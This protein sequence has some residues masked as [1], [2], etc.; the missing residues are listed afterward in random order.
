M[1]TKRRTV[2]EI[3]EIRRERQ[4]RQRTQL[5]TLIVWLCV[6]IILL[7]L[8]AGCTTRVSCAYER[9]SFLGVEW[10]N[11]IPQKCVDRPNRATEMVGW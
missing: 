4:Q 5:C 10:T 8:L 7:W 3:D 11:P 9:K 6:L 2:A 1:E